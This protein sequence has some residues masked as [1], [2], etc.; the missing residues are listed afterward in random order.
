MSEIF[1]VLVGGGLALVGGAGSTIW[2]N[3]RERRSLGYAL[4]G[5]IQAIVD[6]VERKKYREVVDQ[7]IE[8]V[9][10]TKQP[11][12]IRIRMK[13]NYFVVYE[14]NA[15]KIGLLPRNTARRVAR[16]YTYL[17]AIIEDVTDEDYVVQSDTEALQRLRALR[18][19]LDS[20]V[21]KGLKVAGEL[22]KL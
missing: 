1:S 22:E 8:T 21:T 7:C 4:A 18:E 6:V 15:A 19:L 2:Q 20:L 13:Q 14:A 11:H 3:R 5:E 12:S 9:M 16:F 17:K 10:K